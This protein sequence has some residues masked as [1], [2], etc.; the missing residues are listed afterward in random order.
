MAECPL[1]IGSEV[2]NDCFLAFLLAAGCQVIGIECSHWWR[3]YTW[4]EEY[5]ISVLQSTTGSCK[6]WTISKLLSCDNLVHLSQTVYGSCSHSL[7]NSL[8]QFHSLS[9]CE[10]STCACPRLYK[11]YSAN[12]TLQDVLYKLYSTSW[13]VLMT[14]STIVLVVICFSFP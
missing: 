7:W 9:T 13:E 12:C 10:L 2:S 8:T 1:L 5:R 6:N 4:R 3:P 11:L 14:C